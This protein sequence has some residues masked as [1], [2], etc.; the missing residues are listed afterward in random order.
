MNVWS[1]VVVSLTIS[2]SFVAAVPLGG[3]FLYVVSDRDTLY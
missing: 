3:S 1:K 2:I